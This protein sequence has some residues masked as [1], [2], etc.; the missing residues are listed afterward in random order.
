MKMFEVVDN[1]LLTKLFNI[2]KARVYDFVV[3]MN[4]THRQKT[5][6]SSRLSWFTF[7]QW[8]DEGPRLWT[9]EVY[10]WKDG[11]IDPNR[12]RFQRIRQAKLAYEKAGG[13]FK[14]L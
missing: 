2:Q 1:D 4:K 6:E 14:N 3:A 12:K 10:L 7:T 11:T 5:G 8:V 9:E 13:K